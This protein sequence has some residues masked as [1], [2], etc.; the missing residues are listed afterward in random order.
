MNR[1]NQRTHRFALPVGTVALV[2]LLTLVAVVSLHAQAPSSQPK[3]LFEEDAPE[4]PDQP[5]NPDTP[6]TPD[7]PDAAPS[8]EPPQPIHPIDAP[9]PPDDSI[10]AEEITIDRSGVT[11]RDREGRVYSLASED[12][13]SLFEPRRHPHD[14][15]REDIIHVLTD[16]ITIEPG[17]TVPGDVVCVFGGDIEV[18]GHVEGMVFTLFG[19]VNIEG[20]V[21][22]AAVAPFGAVRVG[23]NAKVAGDVIASNIEKEPGGRIG[24]YRNELFFKFLGD[25]WEPR[26]KYWA[27]TTLTVIVFLKTLFW[28]FL[29]LLAHALA[30]RNVAKVKTKIQ[31]SFF[32]SFF[33]GILIQI[34][35]LPLVLLLIMTIV[36]IPVAVFLLPLMIVAAVI[37]SQAA[38]GLFI[39]EKIDENTGLKFP[40]PLG[41]T[42]VGL[43]ALQ[44]IP[45]LAVIFSWGTG[46]RLLGGSF[47]ML[48]FSMVILSVIIGY[49]VV[50]MGTGAV[51]MTRYGTRPKDPLA[52]SDEAEPHADEAHPNVTPLPRRQADESGTAPV[53]G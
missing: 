41:K 48:A 52:E 5:D 40:T 32:K 33:I 30:A 10:Y 35:F 13:A 8:Q 26:G 23:A 28:V 42:L 39:G 11:I 2:F 25:T 4:A 12:S 29:V 53:T 6:D 22:D 38:I 50:T 7:A 24:G 18:L 20:E 47:R 27:Q 46:F 9:A 3:A 44:L 14:K 34:L 17:R 15:D 19:N 45:I 21:D 49:V 1:S 31:T 43:F 36:G 37:L 16:K 51:V